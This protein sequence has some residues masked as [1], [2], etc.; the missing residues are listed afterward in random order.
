MV[1]EAQSARTIKVGLKTEPCSC[2][3]DEAAQ[4]QAKMMHG[5][6]QIVSNVWD[7]KPG[8]VVSSYKTPAHIERGFQVAKLDIVIAPVYP[9]YRCLPACSRANP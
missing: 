4:S 5:K 3:I 2:A 9:V 6:L 1:C 8:D 7:L